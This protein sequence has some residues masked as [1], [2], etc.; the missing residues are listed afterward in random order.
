MSDTLTTYHG[1]PKVKASLLRRISA[2]E[3]AD[4]LTQ[5]TSTPFV[6]WSRAR[7]PRGSGMTITTLR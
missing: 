3:K 5:G 1:D 6:N 2:H 7:T 4:R